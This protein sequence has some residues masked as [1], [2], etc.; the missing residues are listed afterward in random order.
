ML[1]ESE[2]TVHLIDMLPLFPMGSSKDSGVQLD[3]VDSKRARKYVIRRKVCLL[4]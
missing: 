1:I 2:E 3:D 4:G